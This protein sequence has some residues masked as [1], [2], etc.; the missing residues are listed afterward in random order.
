MNITLV[1]HRFMMQ[2]PTMPNS[3]LL[4]S[5]LLNRLLSEIHLLWS[6][7]L[8]GTVLCGVC[9]T[10]VQLWAQPQR[11]APNVAERLADSVRSAAS[12]QAVGKRPNTASAL[13]WQQFEARLHTLCKDFDGAAGGMGVVGVAVLDLTTGQ[14]L[15]INADTQ[16]PAAS[17]IKLAIL[18][19]LFRQHEQS[20]GGGQTRPP[21]SGAQYA[22][23]T[24]PYTL[25]TSDVIAG[26]DVLAGFTPGIT[27]LTNRDVAALMIITSDNAATNILIDRVGMGNVN[28]L[29]DNLGCTNTR[30][31]RKMIDLAA[32]R[33]GRENLA[34][35]RDMVRLLE[36]LHT[37]RVCSKTLNDELMKLLLADKYCYMR[38]L[39]PETV[40]L[41]S[42]PGWLEGVITESGIIFAPNRP[43]ALSV[44][45]SFVRDERA[46]EDLIARIASEAL[47][48]FE[49]LGRSSE[50]G[51]KLR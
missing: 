36:A 38:R 23:L 42:K 16:F 51:R 17:T 48:V 2:P 22:R 47:G 15:A 7:C 21:T 46:A 24:D 50:Y 18:A 39:L 35:P 33:E 13:L 27:K 14:M 41:A 30:L 31:Q 40:A 32:A 37:S 28:A 12:A 20:S 4:N 29:L 9:S 45:T 34:T 11:S 49:R 1:Y 6:L 26:S 25:K 43:F 19:E 3:R 5:R 8:C 44:M 10:H